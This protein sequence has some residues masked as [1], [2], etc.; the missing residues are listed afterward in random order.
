MR[1][2]ALLYRPLKDRK[3]DCYLCAHR[4]RIKDSR[5]GI[6]G[7]RQNVGGTLYTH[8]YGELIAAHVDPIEKKPLYHFL[9]GSS[10]FSVAA[11]GCNFRCGFCQNWQISQIGEVNRSGARRK[12]TTSRQIVDDPWSNTPSLPERP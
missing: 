6:C 3:V 7:V 8:A 9:P 4:W 2:E 5:F 11:P 10:S 12:E 1:K